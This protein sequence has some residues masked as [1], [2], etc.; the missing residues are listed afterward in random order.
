MIVTVVG[1]GVVGGS[2]VKALKGKGYEVYG[3][4]TDEQTL[5][6]AKEEGYIIEGYTDGKE[7]L[8]KSDLTII[9]LYPSI[10][11]D[12]IKNNTFKKGSIISDAVG[13]KSYFLNQ[14]LELIDD[15]IEYVSGHPM[16]GR[17]K[18]GFAYASKEV[19]KGANYIIIEHEKNKK[20]SITFMQNF[21]SDLGFKSVRIMSPYDHD[22]IISF[23]SQLPHV[24]AVSLI[25]SD[26]QKYDTG[27]YIG[28]SYR[29]LT[30]IANINEELWAELFLNNKEYLLQSMN[31]FEEQFDLLKETI[32]SGREDVLK[33]K[34]IQ[35][36]KRRENLEK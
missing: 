10:V 21:V 5:K 32:I 16:A 24:L 8:K 14:A 35:A 31:Q 3:I 34:F 9:C 25:N 36:T 33:E 29:D 12:F 6:I 13:I 4:D 2:F 22:E 7:I 20:E 11:L 23:T 30:R 27:K 15:D 17:E 26:N 18:K 1:L 28:D 19:F